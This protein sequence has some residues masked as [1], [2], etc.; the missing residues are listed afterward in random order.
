MDLKDF[1]EVEKLWD[2]VELPF[3]SNKELIK[4]LYKVSLLLESWMSA[5]EFTFASHFE[6]LTDK[7]QEEIR[8]EIK[9]R[10]GLAYYE[11]SAGKIAKYGKISDQGDPDQ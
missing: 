4:E 10:I 8:Q 1:E 7:S 6:K 11:L 3:E 9:H 5:M 2:F